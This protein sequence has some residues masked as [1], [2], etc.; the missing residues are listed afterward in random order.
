MFAVVLE[1]F[2]KIQ[3]NHSYR[4][5][6]RDGVPIALGYLSVSFG[7]GIA[8][9]SAGLTPLFALLISLTNVTSAG[10]AAGLSII[11]AGGPMIEMALTQL[12]INVRYALMAISL[13]QRVDDSFTRPW[14]AIG[15]FTITDEIFAVASTKPGR[16]GVR[17]FSG[18]SLL[19]YL[20]WAAGTLLGALAGQLLPALISG[21][22]GIMLYGM[23][24]AIIVPPARRERG[25]LVAVLS[26]VAL[27]C[28]FRY[29]PFLSFVS[30]GFALIISA[31]VGACVA[32]LL[33]QVDAPAD[34][35]GEPDA[36]CAPGQEVR[37]E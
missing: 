13:T 11:A 17:Y 24:L 4:E 14:R 5:G 16:V 3:Q 7:F 15:A 9:V 34:E 1:F 27:S 30:S 12:V 8:A 21:A 37:H 19:P 31:V 22:L 6:L 23:F 28:L 36:G 25:V 29:L 26:A 2:M 20:G 33:F 10:Q 32:A 35:T 18:L